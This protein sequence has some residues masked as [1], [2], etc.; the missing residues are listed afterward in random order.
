MF[1]LTGMQLSQLLRKKERVGERREGRKEE[2]E[3]K[4]RKDKGG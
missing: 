1:G 3:G 2:K 4:E